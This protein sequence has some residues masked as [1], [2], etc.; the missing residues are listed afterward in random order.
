[1]NGCYEV[2]VVGNVESMA[3]S[4]VNTVIISLSRMV[5]IKKPNAQIPAVTFHSTRLGEYST[6]S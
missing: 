3:F 5:R 1:M 4:A 2:G 6:I